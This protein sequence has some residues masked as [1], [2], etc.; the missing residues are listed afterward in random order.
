MSTTQSHHQLSSHCHCHS[1]VITRLFS[2][3]LVHLMPTLR[4]IIPILSLSP[5]FFFSATTTPRFFVT[6]AG[7][8]RRP[9]MLSHSHRSRSRSLS[10]AYTKLFL[11]FAC[12]RC[13]PPSHTDSHRSTHRRRFGVPLFAPASPST[14]ALI[15]LLTD[16]CSSR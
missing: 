14:P 9:V 10:L 11:F 13:R 16:G 5:K 2:L 4:E 3:S 6:I 12:L 1:Q 8:E 15:H 7:V